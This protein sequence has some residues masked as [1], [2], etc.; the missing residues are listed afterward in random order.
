MQE[1]SDSVTCHLPPGVAV[2]LAQSI[3]C[4]AAYFL[5]M[6]WN[7]HPQIPPV[8]LL[9]KTESVWYSGSLFHL[10][11]ASFMYL[12]RQDSAHPSI[13]IRPH[14][15]SHAPYFPSLSDVCPYHLSSTDTVCFIYLFACVCLS[16]L[17]CKL[18]QDGYFSLFCL[19]PLPW[20]ARH[21]A[22]IY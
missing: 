16:P 20:S 18:Y 11:S 9:E 2:P 12:F 8:H 3:L 17:V 15:H 7:I 14:F 22:G 5:A 19:L 4:L 10:L 1:P 13:K 6:S 21:R